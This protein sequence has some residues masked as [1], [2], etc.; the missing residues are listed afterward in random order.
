MNDRQEQ[1]TAYAAEGRIW[2]RLAGLLPSA[3][4]AELVQDCWDIGEQ[5]G[6]LWQLVEKLHERRVAVDEFTRAEIAAMAVQWDV[7]DQLQ[8]DILAL[9]ALALPP[10][11]PPAG[12]ARRGP[13]RVYADMEPVEEDG[14]MVVPWMRCAGCERILS[15]GHLRTSWGMSSYPSAY[16]VTGRGE[17]PVEFETEEPGAV[18]AAL[19]ALSAGCRAQGDELRGEGGA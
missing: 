17:A 11:A 2:T 18:W 1:V 5:E 16:L 3:E 7:W 6:G 8:D 9:P 19:S 12:R 15:R 14:R 13:L 10:P 4:D